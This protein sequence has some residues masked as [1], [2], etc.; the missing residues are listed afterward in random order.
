[1][2]AKILKE[3]AESLKRMLID[4]GVWDDSLEVLAED[5]C[6]L[7]P[8]TGKIGF[9]GVEYV[10]REG[11]LVEKK[12][13]SLRHA[14]AGVLDAKLLDLTPSS[15]DII[16]DIAVLDL[17]DQLLSFKTVIGEK[18]IETFKNVNVALQK[19]GK[20]DSEYRVPS[21]EVIAGENRTTTVHKEHGLRY[22]LDVA[23]CYFS[24][25]SSA[26]RLRIAGQV[27]AGERVLVMF[28]GVGPFAILIAR[29]SGA[30]VTAVEL[31]PSAVAFMR[32]NV[33]LNKVDVEVHGGDVRDIVPGLGKFDRILMPLPKSASR[34]F[35]IALPALNPAGIVHYYIFT[36]NSLEASGDAVENA[37]TLGY[38]V[39]VLGV[40]E[41]G[42]YS[43]VF[44]RQC[45]DFRL[46]EK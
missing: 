37:Y 33:A 21:V 42:S 40:H 23:S 5:D 22:K 14:L 44:K 4:S 31:N 43:P 35:D 15:F 8:V 45:V 13:K 29:T 19:T 11:R 38:H 18:L 24:P 34:F 12:P 10:E 1:M 32:E 30:S 46:K 26:E 17:D 16:G 2:Y 6:I 28:A 36:K 20:V 27:K 9:D 25:R 39:E 41:C 3:R 7:F